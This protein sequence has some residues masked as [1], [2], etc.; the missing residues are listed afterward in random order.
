[1]ADDLVGGSWG[2]REGRN[3]RKKGGGTEVSSDWLKATTHN[4]LRAHAIGRGRHWAS[5]SLIGCRNGKE[6]CVM[7]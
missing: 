5:R 4:L 7:I 6:V 1:M 2:G 3:E